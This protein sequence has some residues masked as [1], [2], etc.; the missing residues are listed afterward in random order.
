MTVHEMACLP[1]LRLLP[2]IALSSNPG[3]L[4]EATRPHRRTDRQP[5]GAVEASPP[6]A[7]RRITRIHHRYPTTRVPGGADADSLS[8]STSHCHVNRD[9]LAVVIE[10][11][12]TETEKNH[13]N[14]PHSVD[15]SPHPSG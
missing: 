3:K 9:N 7:I 15:Y 2:T 1:R 8:P 10:I 4:V 6:R 5:H 12:R 13:L 14:T 11:E